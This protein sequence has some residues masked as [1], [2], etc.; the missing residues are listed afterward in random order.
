MKSFELRIIYTIRIASR[1]QSLI[2]ILGHL[3]CSCYNLSEIQLLHLLDSSSITDIYKQ[4]STLT[5][6]GSWIDFC[7]CS[8]KHSLAVGFSL[9][10][11]SFSIR[12]RWVQNCLVVV[13]IQHTFCIQLYFCRD[14][15]CPGWKA[16]QIAGVWIE[17]SE[18]LWLLKL[19]AE[20]QQW[21]WNQKFMKMQ[22][23]ARKEKSWW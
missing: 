19:W 13:H 23:E 20:G 22:C 15:S 2:C 4:S 17:Q 11:V 6:E 9:P 1:L 7:K 14:K 12:G 10:V 18:L 3:R 5:T 16:K 8:Y 21:R